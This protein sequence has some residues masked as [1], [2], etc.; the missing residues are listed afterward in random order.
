M[1]LSMFATHNP[2][3]EELAALVERIV[4]T[5]PVVDMHTHLYDPALGSLLLW[6]IDEQLTYHYLVAEAFRHVQLPYDAFWRL[7][8]REQADLVWRSLFER[9]S[10]VSEAARGVITTLNRLGIEPRRNDL[11]ALRRWF[12][13]WET[14]AFI[15]RCL[16]L[17]R[18]RS[19]FMTNSPF[20]DAERPVWERGFNRDPR[21]VAALRI[22][23][24][25]LSWPQASFHLK[26][27]GYIDSQ[28]LSKSAFDGARRFL[29]DWAQRLSAR[30]VMVSLPPSFRY[31]DTEATGQLIDNVVLPFCR[32]SGLPFALMLGVK[33]AVN[34]ALELAGDG[35]GRS[36]LAALER[37]CA[38][39]PEVRFL[40]TVLSKENQHDLCVIA[41]KF[42]NL[43]VFGCWW[44][45]NIPSVI[46]EITRQ[47]LELL[48]LTFT[49]Q[50]SDA[51]VLDQLIYKWDH[52]RRLIGRCLASKYLGL[53]QAGWWPSEVEIRRDVT[54][55]F[56]GAFEAFCE[57][58]ASA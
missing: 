43:H 35:V 14:E 19:V 2:Q 37:L 5:T 4:E 11:P 32:E 34:P 13:E 9:H 25:L 27:G 6:G 33:R 1:G 41:R 10:P 55:L 48:G 50:H 40:V 57:S 49:P 51:R 45:T 16:E 8:K 26:S 22:D 12:S 29:R 42:R 38:A 7:S 31:P 21:F 54:H 44:F 36:D 28:E 58:G 46:D 47:R 15:D 30:Y 53:A 56:G 18:V 20:D 24:L 39:H 17:A 3:H 52:S 23:P